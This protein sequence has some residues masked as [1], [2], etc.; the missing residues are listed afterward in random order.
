VARVESAFKEELARALKEGFTPT[1]VASAKSGIL[2]MR[3]Q[4]RA[5][6]GGLAAAW[7]ANM[8]LGR[9]FAFSKQFEEKILALTADDIVAALR[10]HVDPA[11]LSVVKAGNFK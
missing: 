10:K 2:Q 5:Q 4:N 7:V 3:V 6:D 11:K 1:E 9:T 8:H